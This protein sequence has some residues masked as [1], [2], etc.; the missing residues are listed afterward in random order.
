MQ[1]F[2]FIFFISIISI[3]SKEIPLSIG[4]NLNGISDWSTEFPFIDLFKSSRRWITQCDKRKCN[5]EI[6]D[7]EEE[8]KLIL[9]QFGWIKQFPQDVKF[10]KVSTIIGHNKYLPEG[11]YIIEY[12]GEGI[13]EYGFSAKKIEKE[14][15]PN[16]DVIVVNN[17]KPYGILLSILSTDP[18]NNGNYIK[19]IKV[20][21]YKLYELYKKNQIFHPEFLNKIKIFS[22]FRFMDWLKTNDSKIKNWE[23]RSKISDY[24]Y[25]IKGVPIEITIELA[26]TLQKD[27]WF[28]IPHQADDNYI[29][30]FAQLV[31]NK[32]NKKSK[33]Y[34]EYS[35][36]VWNTIFEQSKYVKEQSKKKWGDE[37]YYLQWYSKRSIEICKIWK[38]VFQ[39]EKDRVLCVLSTW[40]GLFGKE[41]EILDCPKLVEEGNPPCYKR[42]IDIYA[43]TGYFGGELG[44]QENES[45]ILKWLENKNQAIE[46]A[47]QQ[48]LSEDLIPLKHKRKEI[49]EYHKKIAKEKG[50]E[51]VAYEGGQHI[52]GLKKTKEN[53]KITNFFI[54]INQNRRM[55]EVYTKILNEWKNAG[56]KL[57]LHF[58]DIR[59]SNKHGSWG[60]LEYLFQN[61]SPKYDAL[62]DFIESLKK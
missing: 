10:N 51:L 40:T 38:S 4:T 48:L 22:T 37:K 18:K 62:K 54:E 15:K 2:L 57:F 60:S 29:L 17:Q 20:I 45:L 9:D 36:E 42:D 31:K 49:F 47:F 50:L 27:I 52:V 35:N 43:I 58:T 16:R 39:K 53:E 46:N 5:K 30:N 14:S 7:T 12:E 13:I 1:K 24:T 56:G 8:N 23:D 26:N 34:I 25:S 41:K 28:N 3:F 33:I 44:Y 59:E 32:I 55:Y 21:P 19:N 11:K 61:S 6:W